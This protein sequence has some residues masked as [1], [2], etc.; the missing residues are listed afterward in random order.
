[1]SAQEILDVI[2]AFFDA[3]LNILKALGINFD[4]TQP[5]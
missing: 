1:M 3:L 5:E 2:K 4:K